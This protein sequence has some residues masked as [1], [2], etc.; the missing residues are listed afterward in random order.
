MASNNNYQKLCFAE[1]FNASRLQGRLEQLKLKISSFEGSNAIQQNQYNHDLLQ[2]QTMA[3][4]LQDTID[5]LSKKFRDIESDE[6]SEDLPVLKI[7]ESRKRKAL[8]LASDI[9]ETSNAKYLESKR[10]KPSLDLKAAEIQASPISSI[11]SSISYSEP[12]TPIKENQIKVFTLSNIHE[13]EDSVT[14][15]MEVTKMEVDKKPFKPTLKNG[16]NPLQAF[17]KDTPFVSR[18]QTITCID[19]DN[20]WEEVSP[21][22]K[23]CFR[24]QYEDK[25]ICCFIFERSSTLSEYEVKYK[26]KFNG[27]YSPANVS[28]YCFKNGI[29]IEIEGSAPQGHVPHASDVASQVEESF[30]KCIKFY[31]FLFLLV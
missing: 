31:N 18:F 17:K 7:D 4:A 14:R 30:N 15:K 10:F 3:R 6:E 2:L 29:D 8:N 20:V 11:R 22:S 23:W 19:E 13:W 26:H 28:K 9:I 25:L 16:S 1:Q 12:S 24:F 27:M 5:E 21:E